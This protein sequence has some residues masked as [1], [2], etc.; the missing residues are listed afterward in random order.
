[1]PRSNSVAGAAVCRRARM[2]PNSVDDPVCTTSARAVP[3]I[4][5]VPWKS[6]FTRRAGASSAAHTPTCFSAGKL[7]P[8]NVAS[9]TN[10][11]RSSI[12]AQSAGITAPAPSTSTSPGTISSTATS[13]V[14]PSRT[15]CARTRI[16]SSS[17][18]T[19]SPARYSC[20]K[21]RTALATTTTSTTIASIVSPSKK[22]NVIANISSSTSGLLN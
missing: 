8:V 2:R 19:A 7:S 13:R 18:A 9:S 21:P 5:C 17:F 15:T 12:N 10:R 16:T 1:M 22:D 20:T 3:L 6:A 4:T 14:S 11:S